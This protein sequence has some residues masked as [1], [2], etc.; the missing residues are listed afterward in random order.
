MD[1]PDLLDYHHYCL[2]M[3]YTHQHYLTHPMY[4]HQQMRRRHHLIH[5]QYQSQEPAHL[6]RHQ[7]MLNLLIPRQANYLIQSNLEN[8]R[9]Q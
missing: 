3:V 6:R 8:L 5:H 9:L 1:F 7:K 2:Q 4:T